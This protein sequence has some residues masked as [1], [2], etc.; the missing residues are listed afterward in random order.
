M[1]FWSS[2]EILR[3]IDSVAIVI[4]Q[5]YML[6]RARLSSL[7][8]PVL[9]AAIFS[10]DAIW[11]A[12]LVERELAVFREERERVSAKQRFHYTPAHRFEILQ[13][14]RLRNW[15]AAYTARRFALHPNTI[16]NWK[17][18]LQQSGKDNPFFAGPIWNK[19]HD[20][21]R[22]AVQEIR[23]LCP[24]PEC[25]TRTIARH[26]VRAAVQIS[27]SSVQRIL[28]EEPKRKR[29]TRPAMVSPEGKIPNH[30]LKPKAI[31]E[32]WHLDLLEYRFLWFRFSVIGLIDGFSRML[33]RLTVVRGTA[34]TSDVLNVMQ[35]AINSYGQ[36]RFVITDHGSQF[37]KAFMSKLENIT[38][39][40]G[41]V[42]QPSFN[43]KISSPSSNWEFLTSYSWIIASEARPV[44]AK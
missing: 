44:E 23:R 3:V 20:S 37:N 41:K 19:I 5:G 4:A 8:S 16:R 15:S 36:P 14:M 13:I 26:I 33:L 34:K 12:Q 28:R 7:P 18:K 31:N 38:V 6:A 43:G 39:V 42:R 22:W 27:R 40:K 29:P 11:N 35:A 9:Q 25:G 1:H 2:C 24:T 21:V 30:L 32:V 17:K 10:D